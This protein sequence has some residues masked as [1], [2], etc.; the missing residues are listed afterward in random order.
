[1]RERL[2]RG[3]RRHNRREKALAKTEHRRP[4]LLIPF[5]KSKPVAL[6]LG[7]QQS[8]SSSIPRNEGIS[9]QPVKRIKFIRKTPPSIDEIMAA[10][11]R[12][13]MMFG[14]RRL[15]GQAEEYFSDNQAISILNNLKVGIETG[16]ILSIEEIA[17]QVGRLGSKMGPMGSVSTEIDVAALGVLDAIKA[18][19]NRVK[20]AG[21]L[22]TPN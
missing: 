7:V 6:Q 18:N 11:S 19:N 20:M 16:K 22:K 14:G 13:S 2:S 12:L 3:A 8:L 15:I 17:G 5:T 1:M 21:E 4:N 10:G 9:E